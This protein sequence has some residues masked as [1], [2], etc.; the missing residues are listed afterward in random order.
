[1]RP[2][3]GSSSRTERRHR[4][5][6]AGRPTGVRR[7][8]RRVR[9]T[10]EV[11]RAY[12]APRIRAA[13]MPSSAIGTVAPLDLG[14]DPPVPPTSGA[15]S[16][17]GVDVVD[18]KRSGDRWR[19]ELQVGGRARPD[20]RGLAGAGDPARPRWSRAGRPRS[21]GSSGG[22]IRPRRPPVRGRP[23][24]GR[25]HRP[26]RG[27]GGRARRP[28]PGRR[29]PAAPAARRARASTA[30]PGSST[31]RPAD[32]DLVDARRPHVGRRVRVGGLVDE[33]RPDGFTL[34][35]GTATGRIVLRDAAAPAAAR[36]ARR[37]GERHRDDRS[38]RRRGACGRGSPSTIRRGIAP[39]SASPVA[40][41]APSLGARR[42]G[43]PSRAGASRRRPRRSR[44]RLGGVDAAPRRDAGLALGCAVAGARGTGSR[45]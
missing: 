12:G 25:G 16:A 43:A 10:G 23:A 2:A 15:S 18:V 22:R 31:G 33:L 11:G 17:S 44:A 7:S 1:M 36:R 42:R 38:G 3:A 27:R 35:D 4:G 13:A 34:D 21:S 28:A 9:V 45:R 30:R 14:G 20:R 24:G 19:A 39:A 29:L 5:P 8:G 41:R 26:R 6:A 32:V 40:D 37:R